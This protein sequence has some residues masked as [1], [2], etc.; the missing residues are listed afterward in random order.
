MHAHTPF[1]KSQFHKQNIICIH[2]S[3]WI[4]VLK[5]TWNTMKKTWLWKPNTMKNIKYH[6]TPLHS[7]YLPP[8]SQWC[9]K[10]PKVRNEIPTNNSTTSH[11]QFYLAQMAIPNDGDWPPYIWYVFVPECQLSATHFDH[12]PCTLPIVEGGGQTICSTMLFLVGHGHFAE[13]LGLIFCFVWGDRW[14]S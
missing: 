13:G 3:P 12:H 7:T 6:Q 8:S 5:T 2:L 4:W 11:F 14:S 9:Q 10:S 1:N